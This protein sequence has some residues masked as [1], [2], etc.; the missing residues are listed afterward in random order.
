M[1]G[2]G[3]G[4]S[5]SINARLSNGESVLT[6]AATSMFAPALSA[7]NQIGGG[8]PIM[9][10]NPNQQMGEEFL[11]NAVARGMAMAPAP[12]VKEINNVSTRVQAIER[13][14]TIK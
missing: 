10:Q 3:T 13:L 4:T 12:V 2:P 8:V 7:F 1:T 6:A 14:S 9:G 5:D 11:A